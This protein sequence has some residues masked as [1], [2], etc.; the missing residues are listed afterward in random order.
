VLAVVAVTWFLWLR[1]TRIA[2]LRRITVM[3]SKEPR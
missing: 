2:A 1:P 3:H